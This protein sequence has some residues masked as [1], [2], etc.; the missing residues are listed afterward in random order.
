MVQDA[1][2]SAPPRN[3]YRAPEHVSIPD[4]VLSRRVIDHYK[5]EDAVQAFPINHAG[6]H[7]SGWQLYDVDD[8]NT[9]VWWMLDLTGGRVPE[10]EKNAQL[11]DDVKHFMYRLNKEGGCAPPSSC[12]SPCP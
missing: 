7:S 4:A 9:I 2:E 3:E 8:E 1:A 6:E 12:L 5:E 11:S 10:N